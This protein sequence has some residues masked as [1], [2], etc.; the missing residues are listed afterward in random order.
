ME[1]FYSV[2]C[3]LLFF[4]NFST[5]FQQTLHWC[6]VKLGTWSYHWFHFL[7]TCNWL[8]WYKSKRAHAYVGVTVVV[9]LHWHCYHFGS[10]FLVPAF[11]AHMVNHGA[12]ILKADMQMC[13]SIRAEHMEK[14]RSLLSTLYTIYQYFSIFHTKDFLIHI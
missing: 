9:V 2:H 3:C 6:K 10:H 8:I 12:F 5:E 4:W 1:L 7:A 11:P 14:N 13:I